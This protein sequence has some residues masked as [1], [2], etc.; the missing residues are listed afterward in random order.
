MDREYIRKHGLIERYLQGQLS[1]DELEAFEEAYLGDPE[2]VEELALT[3]KL[4]KGFKAAD[5]AQAAR[6][7]PAWLSAL[8]SVPYAA[9]ATVL[10]ALSLTYSGALLVENR[11]LRDPAPTRL[12]PLVAV[13]G[14]AAPNR[15]DAPAAGEWIV[16]MLDAGFT[17]Y[18]EYRATVAREGANPAEPVALRQGLGRMQTAGYEDQVSLGLPGSLL[19][20]G[21]YEITLEGRMTGGGPEGYEPIRR[22][23]LEVSLLR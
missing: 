9:A 19:A 21:R 12:V 4:R 2:L 1:G 3:E 5:S 20:P 14:D 17:E 16:L 6:R 22:T 11:G 18:D 15:I 10:L 7:R 23:R 13:R 8:G